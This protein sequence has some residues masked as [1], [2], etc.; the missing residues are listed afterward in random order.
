MTNY[1]MAEKLSEKMNVTLEEAKMALEAC[2]WDLL[3]ATL[4]LERESGTQQQAAY[5]TRTEPQPEPTVEKH[6]DS[7]ARNIGK[8][9]RKIIRCGNRNY[10]EIWRKEE[11]VLEIPVTIAVILAVA[12]FWAVA[13]LLV[14]GLFTGFRYRFSGKELGTDSINNVMNKASETAEKVKQEIIKD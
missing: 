6:R 7:T 13:V 8:L 2:N 1:E 11:K 5:S 3:D 14:I 12:G 9:V 4:L 10:F